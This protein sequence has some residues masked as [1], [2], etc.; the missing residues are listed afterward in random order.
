VE[1][2]NKDVITKMIYSPR[3]KVI[4]FLNGKKLRIFSNE[5]HDHVKGTLSQA[6]P[7]NNIFGY[8]SL[9]ITNHKSPSITRM[10]SNKK[11]KVRRSSQSKD[12]DF[13]NP[14]IW[15]P[16][17]LKIR[18]ERASSQLKPTNQNP[19]LSTQMMDVLTPFSQNLIDEITSKDY[20]LLKD[21]PHTQ[22]QKPTL[23]SPKYSNLL[24]HHHVER[25]MSSHHLEEGSNTECKIP[26]FSTQS[27]VSKFSYSTLNLY[28]SKIFPKMKG[29][30][31]EIISHISKIFDSSKI[32]KSSLKLYRIGKVLGKGSFGKVNLA[33][34][35]L[36]GKLVAVKSLN[37]KH[38]QEKGSLKK[39]MR[40][41][42][43]HKVL[44]HPN[45][46]HLYETFETEK[47]IILV[48]ELCTGGDLLN[49]VRKRRKLSENVAKF[50]FKQIIDG[51]HYI[52]SKSILHRDIKLDNILLNAEGEIK[53]LGS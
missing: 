31:E 32:Y 42:D 44:M 43:L 38:L 35:K 19:P 52:H 13:S 28:S 36:T 7:N 16:N 48:T 24:L 18:T 41:I 10:P 50:I 29:E 30:I 4:P 27:S 39:V 5:H 46:I 14:K 34:H 51:L 6:S 45:I 2:S 33:M 3:I 40:E 11:I 25:Q 23:F 22:M 49:Y 9:S 53:V 1:S 20:T 8:R 37:K 47:H 15:S 21:K 17:C 12:K 26:S